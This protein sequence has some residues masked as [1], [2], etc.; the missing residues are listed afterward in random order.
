QGCKY[1]R[2][3]EGCR[4]YDGS[5]LRIAKLRHT[6]NNKSKQSFLR[7]FAFFNIFCILLHYTK[8]KN[9]RYEKIYILSVTHCSAGHRLQ[10]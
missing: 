6:K 5:G 7:L 10:Q 4:G 1:R 9:N 3:Y 8:P 2:L